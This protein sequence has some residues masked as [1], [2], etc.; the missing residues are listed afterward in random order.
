MSNVNKITAL[1]MSVYLK[2]KGN[3]KGNFVMKNFSFKEKG[4]SFEI[5]TLEVSWNY[6]GTD[7]CYADNE[8][9]FTGKPDIQILIENLS[10]ISPEDEGQFVIDYIALNGAEEIESFELLLPKGL[11]K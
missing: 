3:T 5:K 10:I 2:M 6:Q 8:F 9:T 4:K 1:V 7:F 11:F